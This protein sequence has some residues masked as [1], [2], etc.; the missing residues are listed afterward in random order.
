MTLLASL[1]GG[2]TA[3]VE[4]ALILLLIVAAAVAVTARRLGAPYT[5]GLVLVGLALGATSWFGELRL[6]SDLVFYVFL[7]VL[8]FEA[9]FNL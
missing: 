3:G 4:Q 5:V 7:P 1:S 2:H 6:S 9:A 8:L